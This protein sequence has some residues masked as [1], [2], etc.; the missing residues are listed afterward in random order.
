MCEIFVLGSF[1]MDLVSRAN[2]L[3]DSGETVIGNSFMTNAGGKGA[4]QA[5]TI[6]KLNESV[7]F[8]GAV[9]NDDFGKE[10]KTILDEVGVNTKFL[11]AKEGVATGV[12]C[13]SV[14]S[15]GNNRIIV[16][17][18]A[19]L[20]FSKD[21]FNDISD[22]IE[23]AKLLMLQ[24]E[25]DLE[26][27]S[28]AIEFAY[29]K[30]VPILL[31]PAPAVQLSDQLLSK[32]TYL[33]PNETELGLLTNRKI[34]TTK[35]V[36]SAAKVLVEKGVK[37]VIVTLG[38][39]GAIWVDQ[40]MHTTESPSFKVEAL[41]TV[42]AGDSFNGAL[43]IGVLQKHSKEEILEFANKVGALT[44]TKQGAIQAL[45]TKEDIAKYDESTKHF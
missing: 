20:E 31:N 5:A 16:V 22:Q 18:G 29:K 36:F 12:G 17:P 41:D 43:A 3:P 25:M 39:K 8:A 15:A 13:V 7:T 44:V 42:A 38:D 35:D 10:A 24:L 14:D 26:M 28:S 1:M 23:K 45:P 34:E 9:G 40:E 30:N 2:R 4:N 37:N 32:I 21:D 11:K 27:T 33:T 19:N 6:A